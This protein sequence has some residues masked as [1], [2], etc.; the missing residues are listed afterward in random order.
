MSSKPSKGIKSWHE[1]ERPRERLLLR[2]AHA[3][4][5]AELLAILLR[6]GVQ[7]Q[8]AVELDRELLKR[9]DSLQEMM[10]APLSAWEGIKGLGGAKQ[11]GLLAALELGVSG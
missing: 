9:F 2:G 1:D 3:L 6:V 10:S 4:T 7:G 8:S 5:D 11:A